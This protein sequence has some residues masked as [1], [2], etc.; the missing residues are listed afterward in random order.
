M[1]KQNNSIGNIMQ[2]HVTTTLT[3]G[4]IIVAENPPLIHKRSLVFDFMKPPN[5]QGRM[6]REGKRRK[7]WFYGTK[8][9]ILE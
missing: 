3:R 7:Y 2:Q 4:I 5:I 8:G 1:V 6:E 9:E